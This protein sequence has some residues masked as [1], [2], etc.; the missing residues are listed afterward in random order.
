MLSYISN[1]DLFY[2]D[3][4]PLFSGNLIQILTVAMQSLNWQFA[5]TP[6]NYVAHVAKQMNL[7]CYTLF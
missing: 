3:I 5:V 7:L 6:E 4:Y 2:C 1:N